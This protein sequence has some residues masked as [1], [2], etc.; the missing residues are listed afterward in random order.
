MQ[1]FCFS[2][3]S[4]SHTTH[5]FPP[6]I[7]L[8][9]LGCALHTKTGSPQVHKFGGENAEDRVVA[10]F[11]AER[12]GGVAIN[13]AT[14]PFLTPP[15][16]QISRPRVS[17]SPQTHASS[18][19]SKELVLSHSI[20]CWLQNHVQGWTRCTK[21]RTMQPRAR[22]MPGSCARLQSQHR[23]PGIPHGSTVSILVMGPH[24]MAQSCLPVLGSRGK[25][26]TPALAPNQLGTQVQLGAQPQ[27]QHTI[28]DLVHLDPGC[29]CTASQGSQICYTAAALV[30]WS[31]PCHMALA[32]ACWTGVAQQV[33]DTALA[34]GWACQ[35]QAPEPE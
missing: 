1:C 6:K 35:V 19:Q 10:V 22:P 11:I 26:L 29:G 20:M 14:A 4:F 18:G 2:Y 30:C 5:T 21:P 7:N 13:G 34:L 32:P 27:R 33:Q 24:G 9:K 28:L 25:S 31:G 23:I 12:L 3:H 8:G 16:H 15:W 17:P